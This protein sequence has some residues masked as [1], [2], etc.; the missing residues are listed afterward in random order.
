[1]VNLGVSVRSERWHLDDPHFACLSGDCKSQGTSGPFLFN[2]FI[3]PRVFPLF[4]FS[5]TEPARITSQVNWVWLC[6]S[7]IW[8]Y[9]QISIWFWLVISHYYLMTTNL[10]LL[11]KDESCHVTK[12]KRFD[13]SMYNKKIKLMFYIL[14]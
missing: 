12:N 5:P 7:K 14:F 8:D 11:I 1:M 6:W 4:V 9:F 13:I 10:F 2:H 3:Y